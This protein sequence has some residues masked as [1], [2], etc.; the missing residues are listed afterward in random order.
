LVLEE[1]AW[2]VAMTVARSGVIIDDGLELRL[3]PLLPRGE[4]RRAAVALA[5]LRGWIALEDYGHRTYGRDF[6]VVGDR[7]HRDKRARYEKLH[8]IGTYPREDWE[9]G[10]RRSR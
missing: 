3:T 4:D 1:M 8:G 2:T 10:Y 7:F 9:D 6:Y 5:L